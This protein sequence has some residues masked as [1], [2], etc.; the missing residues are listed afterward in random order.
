MSDGIVR[1]WPPGESPAEFLGAYLEKGL[2]E[3]HLHADWQ[4]AVPELLTTLSVGAYRRQAAS[5]SDVTVIPPYQVHAEGGGPGP[6]ARWRVL[7]LADAVVSRLLEARSAETRSAPPI[8]RTSPAQ[9]PVFSDACA[10]TALRALLRDGESGGGE[11]GDGEHDLLPRTTEWLRRLLSLHAIERAAPALPPAVE[12]ARQFLHERMMVPV[13]L[14]E[15]AAAAGVSASHLARSFGR[16]VG[17]PPM[18]YHGQ[19]RLA[20]AR[21]LLSEGKPSTWVAYE[22]GYAD[23]SH[24]VRRFKQ[25]Y[26]ITPGAFQMQSRAGRVAI[27][28]LEAA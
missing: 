28:S 1:F 18:S 15:T 22:C 17:L 23:Q 21:R 27:E 24:L 3:P 6:A 8:H 11:S 5:A 7:Y 12:R 19:L 20:R 26:R 14:R 2:A 9:G 16:L 4:F 10:A 25:C 13:T